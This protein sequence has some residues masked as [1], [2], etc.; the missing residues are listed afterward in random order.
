VQRRQRDTR[1]DFEGRRPVVATKR[2]PVEVPIRALDKPRV[3][4]APS[5]QSLN[6]QK[7]YRVVS[8]P[9][10]VILKTVPSPSDPP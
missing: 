3:G 6:V 4:S 5:V 7:L 1:R 10:G 2:C 9:L 8:V